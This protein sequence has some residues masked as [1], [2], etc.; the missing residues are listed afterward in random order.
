[1]LF[2][3][4]LVAA[5]ML[6]AQST[7]HLND[8][9]SIRPEVQNNVVSVSGLAPAP[10]LAAPA[11]LS[12]EL[13]P[14]FTYQSHDYLWQ[15]LHNILEHGAIVLVFGAGDEQLLALEQERE[16]MQSRGVTPVIVV[17]R[18]DLE[19]WQLVRR[20]SL[21]Y[22]LLADPRSSIGEQ[23]GVLDATSRR[24]Q[25]AWFVID[26]AGHVRDSGL[27][28]LP[29]QGWVDLAAAALRSTPEPNRTA[30]AD[31]D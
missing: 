28:T 14:D 20:L 27:G 23:Y 13:A 3:P 12:G 30:S 19:A 6:A 31:E 11:P 10:R 26:Q 21:G 29:R 7:H 15:N 9:T 18:R 8:P 25:P 2:G 24:S 17:D 4:L 22:S 1:M 5:S 16:P